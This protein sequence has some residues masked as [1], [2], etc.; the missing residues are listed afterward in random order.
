MEKILRQCPGIAEVVVGGM[1][2]PIRGQRVYAWVVKNEASLQS[3]AIIEFCQKKMRHHYCPSKIIF[4]D[5][6]PFNKNGKA[7][8]MRLKREY[9]NG[10]KEA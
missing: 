9:I 7:D 6:I 10:G 2:D 8:R 3:S 5:E 4:I 1:D